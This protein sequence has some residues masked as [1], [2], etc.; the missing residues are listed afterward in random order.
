MNAVS[1]LSKGFYTVP[2][3]ARLIRVGSTRRIY[4]WLRGYNNSAVGPL[5]WR[6]FQPVSGKEE[7]SFLDLMEVRF[8]EHFREHG[9]K[10]TS[11][12]IA[13]NA[14]RQEL[15]TDHPFASEKVMLVA[16]KADVFVDEALRGAAEE[17]NDPKLRSLTTKNYVIYEAVKQALVPGI[18][19]DKRTGLAKAWRPLPDRFPNIEVN[20]KRAFGQP[21]VPSGIPTRA[22]FD[23][24]EA[25]SKDV[26]AVAEGYGLTTDEVIGAI[27]FEKAL[28]EAPAG[29]SN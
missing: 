9:V 22:L 7:L 25:E 29:A 6:D 24:W 17:A 19:F 27:Q 28:D 21:V 18:S 2:E 14:L 23:T 1:L 26:E 16:D 4:G 15:G 3:A 12:R 20:P 8:V 13:A 5:L 10:L 11:L